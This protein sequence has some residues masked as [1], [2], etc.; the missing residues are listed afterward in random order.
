MEFHVKNIEGFKEFF[1]E[2]SS[3]KIHDGFTENILGNICEP[4][5]RHR[6]DVK[7]PK[8]KTIETV[9]TEFPYNFLE[10]TFE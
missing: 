2:K 7:I 9:L 5:E 3:N 6:Q 4:G 8:K 10:K 1:L